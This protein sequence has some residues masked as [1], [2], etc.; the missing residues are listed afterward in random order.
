MSIEPIVLQTLIAL[1][2]QQSKYSEDVEG[3]KQSS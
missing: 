1:E 3:I 2:E